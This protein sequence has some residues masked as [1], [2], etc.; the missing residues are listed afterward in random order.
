[1]RGRASI[2]VSRLG[3]TRTYVNV[4]P[5]AHAFYAHLVASPAS[6]PSFRS[7]DRRSPHRVRTL[8]AS[9]GGR[10]RN[11][12]AEGAAIY[13]PLQIQLEIR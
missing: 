11:G 6:D 1:M 12:R 2:R 10:E 5:P 4:C 8:L 9:V 7:D 3:L 13:I